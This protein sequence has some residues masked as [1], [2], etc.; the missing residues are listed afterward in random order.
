MSE[1]RSYN[2]D[3][4]VCENM[5]DDIGLSKR[6]MTLAINADGHIELKAKRVVARVKN[7]KVIM[8][9]KACDVIHAR[10]DKTIVISV[11]RRDDNHVS[12]HVGVMGEEFT[13]REIVEI[14]KKDRLES[15]LVPDSFRIFSGPREI[16]ERIQISAFKRVIELS[17][18]IIPEFTEE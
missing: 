4:S 5:A 3:K 17:D 18:G 15:A 6:D 2:R 13:W 10:N 11:V 14:V 9:L 12:Y 8:G 1:R 16:E 7:F